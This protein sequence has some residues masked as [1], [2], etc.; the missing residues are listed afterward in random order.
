MF[1]FF[2][3]GMEII[4][5]AQYSISWFR[6]H[7]EVKQSHEWSR[8]NEKAPRGKPVENWFESPEAANEEVPIAGKWN[9]WRWWDEEKSEREKTTAEAE[10]KRECCWKRWLIFIFTKII[11]EILL[12]F[13]VN[14]IIIVNLKSIFT[15]CANGGGLE[16]TS[17]ETND[18]ISMP[19]IISVSYKYIWTEKC[20]N[21]HSVTWLFIWVFSTFYRSQVLEDKC[22]TFCSTYL[23][24]TLHMAGCPYGISAIEGETSLKSQCDRYARPFFWCQI[25]WCRMAHVNGG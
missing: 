18:M 7:V 17:A 12:L 25:S 16:A 23:T 3:F 6:N 15:R 21:R 9:P 19:Y 13:C 24:L 8:E 10:T 1:G 5:I 11:M 2:L 22:S 20:H 4:S 14:L